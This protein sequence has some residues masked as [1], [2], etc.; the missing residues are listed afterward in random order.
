MAAEKTFFSRKGWLAVFSLFI[1]TLFVSLIYHLPVSWLLSQTQVKQQIPP[2]LELSQS[3]GSVWQGQTQLNLN[4]LNAGQLSWDLSMLS[5]LATQANVEANWQLEQGQVN[6]LLQMPLLSE[7]PVLSAEA[8]Q[9]QLSLT[10]LLK[11]TN[12]A[13]LNSMS[14]KGDLAL[15][16]LAVDLDLQTLWPKLLQGSATVQGLSLLGSDFPPI[17]IVP[18]LLKDKIQLK[19]SAKTKGWSLSGTVDLFNNRSYQTALKVTANS[20]ETMPDWALLLRQQSPRVSVLN[21]GGRW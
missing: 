17:Q 9:G 12:S 13:Q 3:Q 21:N 1:L 14:I 19:L 11:L 6:V 2:Q 20:A 4:K 10:A 15:N 5:L 16:D 7:S 18:E 8:I